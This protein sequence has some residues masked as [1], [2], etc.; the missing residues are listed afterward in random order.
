MTGRSWKATSLYTTPPSHPVRSPVIGKGPCNCWQW[1][2]FRVAAKKSNELSFNAWNCDTSHD[3]CLVC[4]LHEF[5]NTSYIFLT[6]WVEYFEIF[7]EFLS[8]L[9]FRGAATWW[10][11]HHLQCSGQRLCKRRARYFGA[12]SLFAVSGVAGGGREVIQCLLSRLQVRGW[13]VKVHEGQRC[14]ICMK[15]MKLFLVHIA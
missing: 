2:R 11:C 15:S 3:P 8:L 6:K 13:I 1:C 7:G 4:I 5:A 10:G 9:F 12:A 14:L